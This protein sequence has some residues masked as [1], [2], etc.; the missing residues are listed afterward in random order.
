MTADQRLR[1]VRRKVEWADTHLIDLHKYRNRFIKEKPYTIDSEPDPK[2][3]HEGLHRFF[4]TSLRLID[5]SIAC[6][7]GDIVHSLRSALDH[8]ACQL[9]EDEGNQVTRHTMF[10]IFR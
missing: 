1:I 9:V 4:P 3:G 7:V 5:P 8:H 10:P 2:P 6:I